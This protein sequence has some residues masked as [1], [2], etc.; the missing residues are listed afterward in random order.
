MAKENIKYEIEFDTKSDKWT[1]HSV[2][3]KNGRTYKNFV[4]DA[5][6]VGEIEIILKKIS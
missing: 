4:S 1:L 2:V 5:D 3:S 6:T